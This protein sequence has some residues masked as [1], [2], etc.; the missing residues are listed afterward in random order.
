MIAYTLETLT[1]PL[2]AGN[3]GS[4]AANSQILAARGDQVTY[5]F[6]LGWLLFGGFAFLILLGLLAYIGINVIGRYR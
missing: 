4:W 2:A 1:S 6:G 3:F 5:A